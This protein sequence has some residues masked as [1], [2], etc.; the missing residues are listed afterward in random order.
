MFRHRERRVHWSS[1]CKAGWSAG[2]RWDRGEAD[3]NGDDD[4][5]DVNSVF[6]RSVSSFNESV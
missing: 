6:S 3:G 5:D 4:D 2:L 1:G